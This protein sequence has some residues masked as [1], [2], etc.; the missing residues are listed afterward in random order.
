[1]S[2]EKAER[3]YTNHRGEADFVR[4][5]AFFVNEFKNWIAYNPVRMINF[6]TDIYDRKIY[7]SGTIKRNN[8]V[9]INPSIN[10][11]ACE[12]PDQ[13][14]KF[15]KHDV[16]T[17]GVARRFIVVYEPGYKEP[18]PRPII[19]VEASEAWKRVKQRLTEAKNVVGCFKET[20]EGG[21]F[22]DSWYMENHKRMSKETNPLVKG[23]LSTKGDHIRKVAMKI[24]VVSDKPM[25]L[26]TPQLQEEAMFYLD[27]I[28]ENLPKL[29][30]AAGRNELMVPQ[31]K[32]LELLKLAGG[33]M[34]KKK[35]LKE[36]EAD[37]DPRESWGMIKHLEDSGQA[38][39][40][41][42]Q[43]RNGEGNMIERE[44]ILLTEYYET[45]KQQGNVNVKKPPQSPA[46][47]SA[48]SKT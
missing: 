16:I 39:I 41:M 45:Q 11:L 46:S 28:E 33:W 31:M 42:Q 24:D 19:T 3:A 1:M 5:M 8:E 26:F 12:N 36:I 25:L 4:Q 43:V 32:A 29:T 30:V 22:F 23:Y 2:A 47:G 35:F 10:V 15:M 40:R 17:G 7:D 38:V 34:P 9:V 13:L 44:C 48:G 21:R 20:A 18:V 37:L 6:L 27:A 14:V